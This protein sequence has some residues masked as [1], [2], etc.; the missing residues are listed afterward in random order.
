MKPNFPRLQMALQCGS[1]TEA[2][3]RGEVAQWLPAFGISPQ[4]LDPQSMMAVAVLMSLFR[5]EL[6]S[7]QSGSA[8]PDSAPG[9]VQQPESALT[10]FRQGAVAIPSM[11]PVQSLT[12][13]SNFGISDRPFPR[14]CCHA[15]EVLTFLAHTRRRFTQPPMPWVNRTGW[16]EG[17]GNLVELN[18]GR[19]IQ[20][21]YVICPPSLGCRHCACGRR[22]QL[23]ALMGSTGRSTDAF[24]MKSGLMAAR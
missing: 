15:M 8:S 20:T 5:R 12:F 18:H 22:G 21:R 17:Y 6:R 1:L 7:R 19:G 4:R 13:T 10:S 9:A 16:A 3:Y 2:R 24:T 14:R 23:I 11:R